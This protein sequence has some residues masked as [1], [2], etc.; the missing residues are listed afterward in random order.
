M[1]AYK[2][3]HK[4]GYLWS[5]LHH[6]CS[7]CRKGE[8]FEVNNSYNLKRLMKMNDKCP[9]C[10]QY[11]EIEI[12]FYYGTSYVSYVLTVVLSVATF[13]VW[14]VLIG[15]SLSDIRFFWWMG[16]NIVTLIL[17]QPYLMRLSRAIW[18]SFFVRYNPNWKTEKSD[19]PERS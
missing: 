15:F 6:K 11:M 9:I 5:L 17:S 18:L 16:L 8:M 2:R 10:D 7:R 13:I 1:C 12:G 3:N 19:A 14:W 4:P